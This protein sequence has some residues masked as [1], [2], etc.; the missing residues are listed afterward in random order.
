MDE[1]AFRAEAHVESL[2]FVAFGAWVFAMDVWTGKRVWY[3]ET[4]GS[5]S[6]IA[7]YLPRVVA[8]GDRVVTAVGK[9]VTC[10]AYADGALIWRTE[11][12]I[13]TMALVVTEGV[14][15]VGY[16]GEAAAFDLRDGRVLWHD[17]F[18][19]LGTG[20]TAVAAGNAVSSPVPM[21]R[22]VA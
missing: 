7:Q 4:Y 16:N 6:G 18:T 19:N 5:H 15:L 17:P 2:A 20:L 22:G 13:H 10:L 9:T 3:A 14:V 12:P 8:A 21:G 1:G 11:S